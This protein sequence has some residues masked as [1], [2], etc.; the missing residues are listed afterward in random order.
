[1]F[2]AA[3]ISGLTCNATY[4][5]RTRATGPGGTTTGRDRTFTTTAC[6]GPPP[7]AAPSATTD[8][9]TGVS[10][11]VATLNGVANDNGTRTTVTFEYGTT[12][13]YVSSLSATPGTLAAGTGNTSIEAAL[14]GLACNT[15]YHYRLRAMSSAGTSTGSNMT[16]LT[17]P[18]P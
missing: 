16:F 2:P 18:C 6:G 12:S 17:A 10:T 9:A 15:R 7:G 3:T 4:H 11:T 5:F 14:T 13:C 1:M 8:A